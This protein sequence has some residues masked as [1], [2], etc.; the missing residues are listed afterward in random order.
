MFESNVSY[1]FY[2]SLTTLISEEPIDPSK[3]SS[4]RRSTPEETGDDQ[5]QGLA[6]K[7]G[8]CV[9]NE[10][11]FIFH[12]YLNRVT[13]L[14]RL[15]DQTIPLTV[16][17][18]R[19]RD[20]E[21]NL[22][23]FDITTATINRSRTTEN[24]DK[25]GKLLAWQDV[26][27]L[28]TKDESLGLIGVHWDIMDKLPLVM[29][30]LTIK[31]M[32]SIISDAIE[33]ISSLD[34]KP[35]MLNVPQR[36][37]NQHILYNNTA[38][39]AAATPYSNIN[40]YSLTMTH[41]TDSPRKGAESNRRTLQRIEDIVIP[42][43]LRNSSSSFSSSSENRP[44]TRTSYRIG[45]IIIHTVVEDDDGKENLGE[46]RSWIDSDNNQMIEGESVNDDVEDVEDDWEEHVIRARSEL[47][48]I[49]DELIMRALKQWIEEGSFTTTKMET[50]G[51]EGKGL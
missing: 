6:V 1:L 7:C 15:S 44:T 2:T 46:G 49:E 50:E 28:H 41:G 38:A 16:E 33:A 12:Y 5:S 36:L 13:V 40:N 14:L 18:K 34:L 37:S 27:D 24:I 30:N 26:C 4:A 9:R 43:I 3:L 39:A 51:S 29:T 11:P 48:G 35:L 19:P 42:I 47:G 25:T 17:T 22:N 10:Y 31:P 45:R 23:Y 32:S 21:D 8:Y 20:S